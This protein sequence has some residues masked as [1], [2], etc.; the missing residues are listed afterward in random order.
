M[1]MDTDR[2]TTLAGF[3]AAL[4]LAASSPAQAESSDPKGPPGAALAELSELLRI[5]PRLRDFKSV[6]MILENPAFWDSELLIEVLNYKGAYKQAWDNTQIAGSW[7][8]G[9]R[10]S[11]NSQ[12]FSF[13][14]LDFLVVSATHGPAHLALYDQQM[15]DK[16][17][18]ADLAGGTFKTNTL[19]ERKHTSS[20]SHNPKDP[21]SLF[22]P[23]GNSVPALQE[24]G[25]VFMAC[26]NA[27]WEV[28]EK[29]LAKNVNP[30]SLSHEAMAAELTNHLV[31]GVVLTTGIVATLLELQRA[32]FHY[33]G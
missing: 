20:D 9:M 16:Y 23:A 24:R 12:V 4:M 13:R 7:L 25:V 29:L 3:G 22:G 18:L 26:H 8:N 21:H 32:G 2:R 1:S 19:I 28:C 5:A 33:I 10:N 15:W 17:K 31:D 11:L 30:D 27:I 14:H 6:P